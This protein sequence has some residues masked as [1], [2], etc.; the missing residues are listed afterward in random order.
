[1]DLDNTKIFF[2]KTIL[3]TK[4][5]FSMREK[6]NLKEIIHILLSVCTFNFYIRVSLF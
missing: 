3:H 5:Y 6:K 1:M 4:R 2:I